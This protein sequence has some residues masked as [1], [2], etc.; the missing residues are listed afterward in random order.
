M[1]CRCIALTLQPFSMNSAASQSSSSGFI[2]VL[3]LPPEIVGRA[4]DS[5]PKWPCQMRFTITRAVNGFPATPATRPTPFAAA[6]R[7]GPSS[8]SLI[9]GPGESRKNPR[10]HLFALLL[11]LPAA[12]CGIGNGLGVREH[13]SPSVMRPASSIRL[14]ELANSVSR[15]SL[16]CAV[17]GRIL[18][19]SSPPLLRISIAGIFED[20]ASARRSGSRGPRYRRKTPQPVVVP[21]RIGSNL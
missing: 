8:G 2:G 15:S 12:E 17:S 5:P 16:S 14:T 6:E 9:S 21:L 18:F 11:N 19:H 7:N 4:D 3:A 10:L 20:P 13:R 1:I